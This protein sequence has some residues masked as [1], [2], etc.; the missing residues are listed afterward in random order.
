MASVENKIAGRDRHRLDTQGMFQAAYGLAE[1][2]EGASAATEGIGGLPSA[3]AITSV[4]LLGMGGS[5]VAGDLLGAIASPLL[6][7]PVVVAKGYE[8]PAFIGPSSLV[9]AVSF[10]GNTEETLE[11]ATAAARAGAPL[12]AITQGG[13]LADLARSIGAP[14]VPV[15]TDIPQ[16]RAGIGA[17]SVPPLLV[18]E[19]MGMLAGVRSSIDDAVVQLRTRR[20]ALVGDGN[21]ARAIASDIGRTIPLIY[22]GGM[23]G[24]TAA[25]R[26]K[27]Q[28]NENAKSPA[29]WN[30]SP[31]LCHN[32]LAGWGQQGDITRQVFTLVELRHDFEH[33]Q[34]ARR[35]EVVDELV[36]EVMSRVVEVRAEGKGPLAQLFDLV[37]IGDFVSLELAAQEGLDPGPVPVLNHMKQAIAR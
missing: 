11:A 26:W 13:A 25:G 36:G 14:V 16:P 29:F 3:D 23:L 7:V 30:T 21:L 28:V 18:L 6:S 2:L 10:S 27:N 5:G 4:V 17:V 12:V 35:A 19:K 33:P 22:G 8:P 37:L 24:A 34:I 20:E 15:A 31:E 9:F 1:Q 32:E